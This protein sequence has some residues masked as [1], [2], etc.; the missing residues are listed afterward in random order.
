[1]RMGLV[2][3][4]AAV[5]FLASS[6]G[7][8]VVLNFGTAGGSEF[9]LSSAAVLSFNT[10]DMKDTDAS[11]LN[12]LIEIGPLTI[13]NTTGRSV[14]FAGLEVY[15]VTTPSVTFGIFS[16]D[17]LT[18]YISGTLATNAI[19]IFG[20]VTSVFDGT[21][22]PTNL[23]SV[24]LLN[25]GTAPATLVSLYQAAQESGG[26]AVTVSLPFNIDPSLH[27]TH[28]AMSGDLSG[29]VDTAPEPATLALTGLGVMALFIRRKK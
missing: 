20:G 29:V 2:V 17:G 28:T 7:A 12:Y 4:A 10:A 15:A 1:M 6:A 19:S 8:D 26:A 3:A 11:I 9:N 23:T 5:L 18:Q 14:P 25:A 24:A 27:T 22:N 21:D 13:N 16:P